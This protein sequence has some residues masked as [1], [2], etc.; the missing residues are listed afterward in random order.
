MSL[1]ID[2]SVALAW[3]FGDGHHDAAWQV[4]ERLREEPAWVPA[5]FHL[6]VGNGLLTGL[7][8]G[9]LTPDQARMAIVTLGALPI[10]VDAETH[11]RA[12]GGIWP[13]AA[14]Y[15]LTTYDAAYLEL[16]ARRGLTLATLDEHLARAARAI[17]LPLAIA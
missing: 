7:R 11:G 4:V 5:H 8:R 10:E 12:L 17:R 13:L 15:C 1:V 2:A 9:R 3:V 16:A 6:E 14:Q